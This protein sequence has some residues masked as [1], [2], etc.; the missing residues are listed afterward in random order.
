MNTFTLIQLTDQ[1]LDCT[2]ASPNGARYVVQ[3]YDTRGKAGYNAVIQRIGSPETR[4]LDTYRPNISAAIADINNVLKRIG[5][6][7]VR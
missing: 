5:V 3:V 2:V 6:E 4:P 7:V 1:L